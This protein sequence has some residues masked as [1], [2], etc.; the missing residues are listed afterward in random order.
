MILDA[1]PI[2]FALAAL[3]MLVRWKETGDRSAYAI[4]AAFAIVGPVLVAVVLVNHFMHIG[5]I[6]SLVD[7]SWTSMVSQIAELAGGV[8]FVVLGV[9]V[10]VITGVFAFATQQAIRQR[11]HRI[12]TLLQYSAAVAGTA[13]A[14]V[15]LLRAY[16][17]FERGT[18][19]ALF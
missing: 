5:E 19:F 6:W 15:M 10:W 12:E 18:Y 2:V 17:A 14:M 4:G 8:A 16:V 9:W 11:F 3:M 7:H 1:V 13:Y